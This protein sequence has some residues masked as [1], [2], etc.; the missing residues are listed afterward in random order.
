VNIFSTNLVPAYEK[1]AFSFGQ[2]VQSSQ[3]A[4]HVAL[5][6]PCPDRA[7]G[8][9]TFT[10]D[11]LQQSLAAESAHQFQ[12]VCVL[13]EGET[14][15]GCI[16]ID[17]QDITSYRRAA[18]AINE[19]RFGAVWIQHEFGI[20][21]GK[22]GE[23]VLDLAERV[24]APLVVTLHTILER[25]SANQ[26]RIVKRLIAIATQVMVMSRHGKDMLVDLYGADR[27]RV[28]IIEHGAP[29]RELDLSVPNGKLT[30]ATFGL[31]GPGKG[32]ETALYA[33]AKFKEQFADFRYRIIGATHPNL[34]EREGDAYR[35]DIK[36]MVRELGL[37]AQVEW[38]NKFLDIDDL[39]E[40]LDDCQIY[41]TPYPNLQ[42]STSGT[43]SYA[44]ALGKA[45]ISTPYIHAREL[46]EDGCGQLF[47]PGDS[48]ALAAAILDLA[49]DRRRLDEMRHKAYARGR[50][51]I[52]SE[53]V[54]SVDSMLASAMRS[55]VP[56][57]S[58]ARLRAVPGL[59]GFRVMVDGTGILQ[60]SH[61]SV[62]NR[63]HG[64]CVDDNVRALMLMNMVGT[65][66]D[67]ASYQHSLTFCAFI[68]DSYNPDVGHF[69]NFMSYDRRWLEEK[70]SEDSNGRTLWSIG[71][72]VRYSPYQDVR[73]WAIDWFERVIGMADELGSP[74]AKAFAVLGAANVLEVFP[75][76]SKALAVLKNAGGILFQLLKASSR[77]DWKWF[78]TILAY[79]NP[80][81]AE[82]L[83]RAGEM[84]HNREWIDTGIDALRW[85]N[86]HQTSE[87]RMF[88]PV[89]SEG[90]G[91]DHDFLPFDQQPVEAWA[92]IDAC[93]VGHRVRP[94]AE[95]LAHAEMALS[96]FHGNND[97]HQPLVDLSTGACRD[98]IT[99]VGINQNRGAESILAFQLGYHSYMQLLAQTGQGKSINDEKL[100]RTGKHAAYPRPEADGR[101][102]SGGAASV[103]SQLAG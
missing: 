41:L 99:P 26:L 58:Q 80:R 94:A 68:Q 81:L 69:R 21:G 89:G 34:L 32:L 22:D 15:G 97:R 54:A 72:T 62:P 44:V 31:L 25:P 48:D 29:D 76:H 85:I 71:H 95:W 78:E 75:E 101:S 13:R 57:L 61:G 49:R 7:C 77:P 28:T 103:S 67:L 53:F 8:L 38:V 63:A 5:I 102:A 27:D 33:L 12:H 16:S 50:K 74:R 91:R 40:E 98:G 90:F 14:E 19:A 60:H 92:A 59:V 51:T 70:G 73:W 45:V 82:A 42:Q 39:L 64:Y 4:K 18:R 52:W 1:S 79:D 100:L 43:L 30:L 37:E 83:I 6:G 87:A 11:I 47:P 35:D 46:L 96:W 9:A 2:P 10:N 93:A 88:R 86:T 3:I 66:S 84:T 36:K 24:V 23:H 55:E 17:E 56:T 65:Y 20:F